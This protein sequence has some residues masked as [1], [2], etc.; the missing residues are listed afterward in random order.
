MFRF[1]EILPTL[2]PKER[3]L[4]GRDV[5]LEPAELH[6]VLGS[7]MDL[8]RLLAEREAQSLETETIVLGMGCFWG[9]ERR[10]YQLAGVVGS[11]TGY[12]GGHTPNP[13]YEE[14][15]SGSTAHS[16]VVRVSF[17]PAQLSLAE[18]L[19]KS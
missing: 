11:A 13:H 3:C 10:F 9:A 16:E 1:R 14:V 17:D 12:A 7:P 2:M 15:C 5:A 4:K 8:K 6:R 19:K 18:I